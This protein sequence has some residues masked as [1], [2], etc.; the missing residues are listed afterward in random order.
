M[1]MTSFS[2]RPGCEEV[3]IEH[4]FIR[5]G[6]SSR[7]GQMLP[8]IV[9]EPL[10]CLSTDPLDARRSVRLGDAL[11]RSRAASPPRR[12]APLHQEFRSHTPARASSDRA[13]P[14]TRPSTSACARSVS[15]QRNPSS[16]IR[17]ERLLPCGR[18]LL[19]MWKMA[20]PRSGSAIRAAGHELRH[21]GLEIAAAKTAVQSFA[22]PLFM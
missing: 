9:R 20:C 7:A 19:L 2:P 13:G 14:R 5:N 1:F 12:H 3:F 4:Y 15:C 16:V 10:R 21:G 17:A 8:I 6:A 11:V 18:L 22:L